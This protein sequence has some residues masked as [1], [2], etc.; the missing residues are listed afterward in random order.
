M[1][2]VVY[3]YIHVDEGD[4]ICVQSMDGQLFLYHHDTPAF[5]CFLPDFLL[6]GPLRYIP[7]TDSFV[8]VNSSHFLQTF[9]YMIAT[10]WLTVYL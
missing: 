5:S 10:T 3:M 7:R 4:Q 6:P 2:F 8:T 1:Y 9:R